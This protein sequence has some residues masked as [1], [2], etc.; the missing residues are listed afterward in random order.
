MI[1]T[2]D[3][4]PALQLP[5]LSKGHLPSDINIYTFKAITHTSKGGGRFERV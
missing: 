5:H 3:F 4:I 2:T 1:L